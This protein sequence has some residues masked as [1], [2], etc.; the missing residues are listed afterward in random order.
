MSDE[1][2]NLLLT[3][4]GWANIWLICSIQLDPNNLLVAI[5]SGYDALL[6]V[7]LIIKKPKK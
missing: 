5:L 2:F 1:D 4:L 7:W 6:T 3:L